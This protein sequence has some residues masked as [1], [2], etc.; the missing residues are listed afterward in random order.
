MFN[1]NECRRICYYIKCVFCKN[2]AESS[3]HLI[4]Q[5]SYAEPSWSNVV[6]IL[7]R[8]ARHNVI[9]NQRVV[10][11]NIFKKSKVKALNLLLNILL[12]EGS[13]EIWCCGNF[14]CFREKNE[15]S[16]YIKY[17]FISNIKIRL[18]VDFMR[19]SYGDFEVV[20]CNNNVICSIVSNVMICLFIWGFTSLS[21]LYRSYHDR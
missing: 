4:F 9:I 16:C 10:I 19:L 21:T 17:L 14:H 15:D 20:W 13:W 11:L 8:I 5:C 12:A 6:D 1:I 7:S 2:E 18:K 3:N